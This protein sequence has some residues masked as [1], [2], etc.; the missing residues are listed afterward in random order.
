MASCQKGPTRHA[1][2]W[3]I[4][5]FWQNTIDICNGDTRTVLIERIQYIVSGWWPGNDSNLGIG[6]HYQYI[7]VIIYMPIMYI[8][9]HTHGKY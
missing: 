8:I 2:A 4:G 1:Y 6:S 7:N 3:Q 9:D 5:P